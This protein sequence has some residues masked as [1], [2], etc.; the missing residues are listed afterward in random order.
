MPATSTLFLLGLF[1]CGGESEGRWPENPRAGFEVIKADRVEEAT[2]SALKDNEKIISKVTRGPFGPTNDTVLVIVSSPVGFASFALAGTERIEL[3]AFPDS[4]FAVDVIDVTQADVDGDGHKEAIVL[5]T[6]MKGASDT[7]QRHVN[8]VFDWD[9]ERF[10]RLPE[11][12]ALIS[13]ATTAQ[14]AKAL[15]D[16]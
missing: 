14:E 1:A 5:T 9:G 3:P 11:S 2:S 15:L 12:E 4:G 16:G 13:G 6:Y 8:V 7:T 10:Q